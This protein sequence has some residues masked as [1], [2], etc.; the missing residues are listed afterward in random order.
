MILI[1][2]RAYIIA[3]AGV[4]HNGS[5]DLA[6]KL[7]VAALDAGADA[8]KFQTFKAERVAQSD[9]PK[10]QYQLANTDPVESQIE[11]LRKLELSAEAHRELIVL[12]QESGIDFLSTPYNEEDVELL[13]EL[14]VDAFKLASIHAAEPHFLRFVA[15]KKR[16]ILLATG[17][18]TLAE[19]DVAVRAIRAVS[20]AQLALLQCTTNYPSRLEDA[21]LRAITTMH[22]AFDLPV[23]YSDHTEGELCCLA[24]VALGACVIEKHLTLDKTLPGPDHT[25]AAEP[26]Q[27][28]SLVRNIRIAEAALGTGRKAPCEAER[29]NSV[30]MRRSLAARRQIKADELITEEMLTCKRPSNG[31]APHLVDEVVGRR[32][33]RNIAEGEP[34]NWMMLRPTSA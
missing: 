30:N 26:E 34:L 27:F 23:G 2:N 29:A 5:L 12:C 28:A 15:A 6:R 1:P 32:A 19:V 7:V 13:D 33:A 10:A 20:D 3:E 16:P 25:S 18:A 14:G 9:A 24:A 17:M 31:I 11:M 8:V 21:N 4:N 22:A